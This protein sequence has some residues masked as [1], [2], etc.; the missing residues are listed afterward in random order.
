VA[1]QQTASDINVYLASSGESLS[2]AQSGKTVRIIGG[3]FFAVG[4]LAFL[5]GFHGI[6]KLVRSFGFARP[7]GG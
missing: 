3:L 2:L 5:R 6:L 1:H 7:A 4:G